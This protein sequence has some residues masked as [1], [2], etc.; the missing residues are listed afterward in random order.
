MKFYTL[1]KVNAKKNSRVTI[2][3]KE[4]HRASRAIINQGITNG[5]AIV[6]FRKIVDRYNVIKDTS[7]SLVG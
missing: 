6:V 4:G 7:L 1:T 3:S 5:R 2:S